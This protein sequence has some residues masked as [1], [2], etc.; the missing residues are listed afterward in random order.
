MF[1][2]VRCKLYLQVFILWDP[3]KKRI[4][5]EKAFGETK[6]LPKAERRNRCYLNVA[7]WVGDIRARERGVRLGTDFAERASQRGQMGGNGG[8]QVK[9]ICFGCKFS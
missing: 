5:G 8:T 3:M 1:R 6:I 2:E 7:G 9:L 4:S